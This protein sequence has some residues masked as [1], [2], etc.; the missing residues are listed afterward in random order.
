MIG[1]G[2]LTLKSV[3][4]NKLWIKIFG[5]LGAALLTLILAVLVF[6]GGKGFAIANFPGASPAP[7]LIVAGTPEQISRGEYLANISCIGCHGSFPNGFEGD[8]KMPMV[9]G[10]DIAAEEGFGFIGQLGAENLTPGGKLA[11]YSDGEIFRS[12]RHGVDR[13]G[14]LLGI[15]S[16]IAVGELSDDDLE[17]LIAYM[18][19]Q[20]AVSTDSPTG[21]KINFVGLVLFGA[22]LFP[23]PLAKPDIIAAP[24]KGI[25]ADY[26]E[27]V[28]T[29]GDCRSCHGPD[30]TGT[31][32]S[33]LS[34]AYPNPRPL[35]SALTV[36]QFI[37]MMSTGTRPGGVAFSKGM[38]W[39]SAAAMSDDDLAT[40]YTY[41]TTN[42]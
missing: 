12:L 33:A 29:I 32:A 37:E 8:P 23:Q 26:G 28:A 13:E 41:L 36:E 25:T 3:R 19:V 42:P 2:W 15:M 18:R 20:P 16:V 5:G 35:T 39:Q 11:N 1:A 31:P 27:Y 21:D 24:S 38:P 40:L 9:G 34:P 6:F 30:M 4:A 22:G 17:A 10:I 7:D 14:R